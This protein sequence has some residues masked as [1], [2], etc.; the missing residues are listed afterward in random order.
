MEISQSCLSPQ[1][2]LSIFSLEL[3][4]RVMLLRLRQTVI[5]GYGL[6]STMRAFKPLFLISM[7]IICKTVLS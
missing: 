3:A 7:Y 1:L 6:R 2:L 4:S 5:E